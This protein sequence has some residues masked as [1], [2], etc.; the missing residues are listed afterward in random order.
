MNLAKGKHNF[1]S[2]IFVFI[3]PPSLRIFP[4]KGFLKYAPEPSVTFLMI[5]N[6]FC[7]RKKNGCSRF[8][9]E[10]KLKRLKFKFLMF[11]RLISGSFKIPFYGTLRH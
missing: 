10:L 11:R 2:V 4:N 3:T 8:L 9:K 5:F 6:V 1:I 7:L